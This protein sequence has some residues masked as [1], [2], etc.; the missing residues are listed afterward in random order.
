MSYQ[1]PGAAPIVSGDTQAQSFLLWLEKS[2]L[3]FERLQKILG[4][5]LGL[6]STGTGV[7]AYGE[8]AEASFPLSATNTPSMRIHVGSGA[9]FV[10]FAP[11]LRDADGL[12]AL[13]VAPD[14]D[15]RIDTIC[16]DADDGEVVILTGEESA[17]PTAPAVTEDNHLKIGEVYH[18]PGETGIYNTDTS[19][20]GYIVD[21]VRGFNL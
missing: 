4:L 3:A 18:R 10:N 12:T 5:A 21:N 1:Y 13:F 9:G 6:N 2:R 15:A 19:G 20:E 14:A 7:L 8:S 17:S 11:V 16:I